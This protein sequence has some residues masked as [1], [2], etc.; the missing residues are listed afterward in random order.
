MGRPRRSGRIRLPRVTLRCDPPGQP[1]AKVIKP[2]SRLFVSISTMSRHV[3]VKW[4]NAA[5]IKTTNMLVQQSLSHL[6]PVVERDGATG[7][8]WAGRLH[9]RASLQLRTGKP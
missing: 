3:T 7:A 4:T 2:K 6:N 1:R 5:N 9:A 8:P